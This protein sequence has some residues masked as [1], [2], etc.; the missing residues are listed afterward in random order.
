MARKYINRKLGKYFLK[1][2]FIINVFFSKEFFLSVIGLFFL[3]LPLHSSQVQERTNKVYLQEKEG[4]LTISDISANSKIISPTEN[5]SLRPFLFQKIP[6]NIAG[7]DLLQTVSGIGVKTAHAIIKERKEGLFLSS[8]DLTR[9]DGIGL[10]TAKK[11]EHY[12]SFETQKSV[13]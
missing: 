9:V 7:S 8:Y 3:Y 1:K 13:K 10:K 11:L 4:Q 12:F 6:V 5:I 2:E